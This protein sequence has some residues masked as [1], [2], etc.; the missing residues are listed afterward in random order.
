MRAIVLSA[1]VG[2]ILSGSSAG[3]G[4]VH[5]DTVPPV[6]SAEELTGQLQRVLSTSTA[7]ADRAA[8]LEGGQAAVPTANNIAEQMN[9]YSSMMSWAVRNPALNGDRLDAQLAVTVPLFGTR[10][11]QIYWIPQGG[12]WKLSNASA[13]VIAVEAA[14]TDC[15]I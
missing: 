13:C 6:P 2:L 9:R 11:H 3:A 4:Q 14:G 10:T 12:Q 5:A 8:A 1:A 15:T 7:D